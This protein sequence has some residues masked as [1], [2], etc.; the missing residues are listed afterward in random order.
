M[1]KRVCHRW[2]GVVPQRTR[3]SS[4]DSSKSAAFITTRMPFPPPPLTK[5]VKARHGEGIVR[6]ETMKV[7]QRKESS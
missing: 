2:A 4:S 5:K 7:S 1:T 3:A 6:R